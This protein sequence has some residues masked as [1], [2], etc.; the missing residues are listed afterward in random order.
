MSMTLQEFF[1]NNPKVALAFSGGADSAYLLWA[2]KSCGADAQA[3][4]VQTAFQPAFELENARRLCQELGMEL[5]VLPLDILSVSGVADN[6]PERCYFCKRA[7]FSAIKQAASAAGCPQVIDG[8]NASDDASDR[9]GMRALRELGVRSPLRECGITKTELRRLSREAGLFT[10]DKPA[11]ACL[12]TRVQTGVAL[13]QPL[14]A[15][16]ERAENAVSQLGFTDFRVR[17]DGD[18]ARLELLAEQ[19]Q[20]ANDEREKLREALQEFA[21]IRFAERQPRD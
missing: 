9:P 2:S 17:T 3:Y 18:N 10:H 19:L 5:H 21:E 8:T 12:A 16:V 6:T 14:L 13:T 20:R 7:I 11:Y 15:Q 4:Y 1:E